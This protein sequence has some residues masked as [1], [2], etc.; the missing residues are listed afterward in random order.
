MATADCS[1]LSQL[2]NMPQFLV[3]IETPLEQGGLALEHACQEFSNADQEAYGHK[4]AKVEGT[5]DPAELVG[6]RGPISEQDHQRNH[7]H[8]F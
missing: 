4:E 3:N 5:L 6:E 1:K 7:S 2:T 8:L